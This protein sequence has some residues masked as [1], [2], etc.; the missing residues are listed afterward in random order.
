MKFG[1]LV[2]WVV[3]QVFVAV[4]RWCGCC[5]A[6]VLESSSLKQIVFPPNFNGTVSV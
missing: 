6:G 2:D 3:V 5:L 1:G 4:I